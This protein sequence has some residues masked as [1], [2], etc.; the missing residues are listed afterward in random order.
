MI[1]AADLSTM[2]Y[3]GVTALT[4]GLYPEYSLVKKEKQKCYPEDIFVALDIAGVKLQ[5]LLDITARRIC[6]YLEKELMK[7][8]GLELENLELVCQW[9]CGGSQQQRL[10]RKFEKLTNSDCFAFFSWLLPLKFVSKVDGEEKVWWRNLSQFSR[11][12]RL[13]LVQETEEVVQKEISHI[14]NEVESV[15]KTKVVMMDG[16]EVKHTLTKADI[17]TTVSDA[18]SASAV[19]NWPDVRYFK[20]LR[21]VFK[22]IILYSDPLIRTNRDTRKIA[23]REARPDKA[24]RYS[25]IDA[26]MSNDSFDTEDEESGDG[27]EGDRD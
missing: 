21:N 22:R 2:Q 13:Q 23:K 7:A 27:D 20:Y 18:S 5:H 6:A 9:G 15:E 11:P 14:E 26:N 3:C 12:I 19:E 4:K 25:A 10:K 1:V 24:T 17:D 8:T 16:V